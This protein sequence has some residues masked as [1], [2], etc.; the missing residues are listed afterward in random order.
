MGGLMGFEILPVKSGNEEI[1][2]IITITSPE[3]QTPHRSL[4]ADNNPFPYDPSDLDAEV[5]I[6]PASLNR[7][8]K[9]SKDSG[10]FKI[11]SGEDKKGSGEVTEVFTMNC[12]LPVMDTQICATST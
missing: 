12:Q 10:E 2:D 8:S 5:S 7:L 4:A 11:G 3:K 1:Y 6:Y 9:S